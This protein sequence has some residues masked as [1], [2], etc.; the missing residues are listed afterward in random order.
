MAQLAYGSGVR[1][2]ELVEVCLK[3]LDSDGNE[4]IVK[5][6]KGNIN[7]V[8]FLPKSIQEQLREHLEGMRGIREYQAIVEESAFLQYPLN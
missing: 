8:T 5:R 7:R 1:C 6:A 3:D 2:G 4:L